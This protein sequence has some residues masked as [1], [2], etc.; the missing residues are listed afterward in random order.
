MTRSQEL[1]ANL[2]EIRSEIPA[3]VTLICVT[4]TY[5]ISDVEILKELGEENFG[6]NRTNELV[7]KARAVPATWHFQG[8]IQSNKLRDIAQYADVVHSLDEIAHVR[9]LDALLNREISAFI[10]VSLDGA[11]GRGGVLPQNLSAIA[12]EIV[13]SRHIALLGLMAVAPL[14]EDADRA[15]ARLA[16]FHRDFCTRYPSATS[17]S[18]GMSHDYRQALAH[19][20]THLRIGS[21]ILGPRA[22]LR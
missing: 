20:A 14:G 12:D 3:G 2:K 11:Q 1:A 17:L 18:A 7:E 10:Q 22:G 19:G 6:E 13:A 15:F 21:Q 8:Q 16:T 4:K 9:K 5:P